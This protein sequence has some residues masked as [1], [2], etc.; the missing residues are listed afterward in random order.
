MKSVS[1]ALK[2]L[3]ENGMHGDKEIHGCRFSGLSLTGVAS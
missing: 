3:K 2:L 1:R